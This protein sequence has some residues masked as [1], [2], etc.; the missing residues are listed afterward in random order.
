MSFQT[1][2]I[3]LDEIAAI[4]AAALEFPTW[5]LSDRQICD[6]ELILNGAFFPLTGFMTEADASTVLERVTPGRVT[7]SPCR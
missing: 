1:R 4:R 3:N 6:V 7:F 5:G 2:Y